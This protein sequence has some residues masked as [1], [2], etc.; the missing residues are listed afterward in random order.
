MKSFGHI[1]L[2]IFFAFV[3]CSSIA[4]KEPP[5]PTQNYQ[6]VYLATFPRS[7]NHWMRYLIEEV[8][9]ITT[10]S[11]YRDKDPQHLAKPFPWGGYCVPNGYEGNCRYPKSGEFVVIKTHFPALKPSQYDSQ[12]FAKAIRIIRHP[13]DS[14]YSFYVYRHGDQ[15]D[16]F[17]FAEKDLKQ[18]IDSWKKFQ[19]Y[20]DNQPNVVTIRFEDLYND[21]ERNLKKVMKATGYDFNK[22]DIERALAK[23][24]PQG[25]LLKHIKHYTSENFSL[26]K[27]ELSEQLEQYGYDV[28]SDSE[29]EELIKPI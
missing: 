20:W 1:I 2:N 19:E 11:V 18:F 9:H 22:E 6:R 13:I 10:S 16:D 28:P 15:K 8:T 3:L 27:K 5:E 23:F 29:D 4:A 21:P 12:P 24:P 14:F 7:G 25:G 26:I 17:M